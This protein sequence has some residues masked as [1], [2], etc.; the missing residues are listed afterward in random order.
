M[1]KSCLTYY[2]NEVA[3]N[4]ITRKTIGTLAS[5]LY[6]LASYVLKEKDT[7]AK[8]YLNEQPIQRG[9]YMSVHVLLYLL[10]ELF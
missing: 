5:P 4:C 6:G 8:F 9:S 3:L 2:M 10:N 1:G 7:R